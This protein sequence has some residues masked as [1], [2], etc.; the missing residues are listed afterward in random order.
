[1]SAAWLGHGSCN[2]AHEGLKSE[3]SCLQGSRFEL[4]DCVS[5]EG[6]QQSVGL[7][8]LGGVWEGLCREH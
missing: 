6:E 3:L 1:M 5:G 2:T 8:R 4:Q 7:W